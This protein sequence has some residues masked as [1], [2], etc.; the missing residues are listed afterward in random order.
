MFSFQ[1]FATG[2]AEQIQEDIDTRKKRTELI[3]DKAWDDHTKRYYEKR[4]KEEAK[5]EVIE[6]TIKSIASL[7]DV[8]GNIDYAASLYN[9]LGTVENASRW[10]QEARKIE[11]AG[12][13]LIETNYIGAMPD[14][15]KN[16]GVSVEDYAK[17]FTKDI[18][19]MKGLTDTIPG[20]RMGRRISEGLKRRTEEMEAAGL[21]PESALKG[22][23]RVGPTFADVSI[24]LTLSNIDQD[25]DVIRNRLKNVIANSPENSERGKNA[26]RQLEKLNKARS[27]LSSELTSKDI[28]AATKTFN[29]TMTNLAK[30]A[31]GGLPPSAGSIELGTTDQLITKI[32][33]KDKYSK[34]YQSAVPKVM[35]RLKEQL[36]PTEYEK[37]AKTFNYVETTNDIN[38][39]T[40]KLTKDK[41]KDTDLRGELDKTNT[42]KEVVGT[43]VN[44][45]L[46]PELLKGAMK[47]GLNENKT[48]TQLLDDF[49]KDNPK[50]TED[51][52]N[53]FKQLFDEIERSRPQQKG[54][55]VSR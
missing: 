37:I 13:S 1:G 8:G 47:Q 18:N 39:E 28:A 24:D 21:I 54:R 29:I 38:K 42:T 43:T 32:Q 52:L 16:S 50:A 17:S 10:L 40:N 6:E 27:V 26:L 22:E 36:K 46:N 20:S 5:A 55:N 4:D 9:K 34:W 15:F 23:P 11:G 33:D 2:F 48:Y 19:F 12:L 31:K 35:K 41:D 30:D 49:K 7:N 14:N 25:F 44:S 53:L 3:I 45:V 51:D